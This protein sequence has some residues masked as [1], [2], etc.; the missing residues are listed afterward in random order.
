MNLMLLF[1][2]MDKMLGPDLEKGLEKLKIVL[3]K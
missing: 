2:D 3:E 1:M